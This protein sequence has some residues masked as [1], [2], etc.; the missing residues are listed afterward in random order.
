MS[1][2]ID[3]AEFLKKTQQLQ[4]KFFEMA[5]NAKTQRELD[6]VSAKCFEL[7][8]EFL[9]QNL[10]EINKKS[11]KIKGG[12]YFRNYWNKKTKELLKI[13]E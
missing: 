10:D 11:I 3:K 2:N 8:I 4:T 9:N 13:Y 12:L 1:G 6:Q 7:E 5:A